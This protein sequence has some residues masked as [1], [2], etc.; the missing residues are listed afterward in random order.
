MG[1]VSRTLEI[2]ATRLNGME[3]FWTNF[4]FSLFKKR[5]RG[6][7]ESCGLLGRFFIFAGLFFILGCSQEQPRVKLAASGIPGQEPTMLFEGFKMESIAGLQKEWE[8]SARSAQVFEREQKAR[9]QD[10]LVVYWRGGKPVSRLTAKKGIIFIRNNDI[11]AEQN[12][13]MISE[14]GARLLTDKLSW[15]NTHNLIYTNSPVTIIRQD[16]ILTGK[17]LRADKNLKHI[18]ILANVKIQARSLKDLQKMRELGQ[19]P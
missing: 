13:E 16:T 8:F 9:A 12:V 4:F 5:V 2:S 18:E 15:D 1:M 19:K 10:I 11:R 6:F 3:P 17:G 7:S 14:E